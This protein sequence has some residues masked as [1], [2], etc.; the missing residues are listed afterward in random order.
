[1]IG[2]LVT[3]WRAWCALG[4]CEL[5]GAP[6]RDRNPECPKCLED[7]IERQTL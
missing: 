4:N 1:M 5:C 3:L 7:A 2:W 6:P